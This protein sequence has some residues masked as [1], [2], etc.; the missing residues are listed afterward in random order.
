MPE[1]LSELKLESYKLLLIK[2]GK[3]CFFGNFRLNGSFCFLKFL[4]CLF[5]SFRHCSTVL[6]SLK[7]LKESNIYLEVVTKIWIFIK[8]V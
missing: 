3:N 8:R 5:N 7:N 4:F 1:T 6:G 2:V